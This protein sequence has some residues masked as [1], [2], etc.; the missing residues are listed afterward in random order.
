[1]LTPKVVTKG[2]PKQ[3]NEGKDDHPHKKGLDTPV[4]DK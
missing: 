1:M 3:K 4:G 2:L